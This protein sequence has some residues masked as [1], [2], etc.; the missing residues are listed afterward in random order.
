MKNFFT[1]QLVFKP[2]VSALLALALTLIISADINSDTLIS[3]LIGSSDIEVSDFYN[4]VRAGSSRKHF[5]DEII[6]VNIDSVFDRGELALILLSLLEADVKSVGFDVILQDDK[7]FESD[8]FLKDVLESSPKIVASQK[9][10]V[11]TLKPESDF[12]SRYD[13]KV[14]RGMANLVTKRNSDMVRNFSPSMKGE[15]EYLTLPSE[16]IRSLDSKAFSRLSSLNHEEMI[17]FRPTEFF[18]IEPKDIEDNKKL[19]KDKIVFLGTINEKDDLHHTPLSR[20]TPGVLIQ[21]NILSMMLHEDYT[22]GKS[23]YFNLFFGIISCLGLSFLYVFLDNSQNLAIRIIPIVWIFIVILI[24]CWWFDSFA[25]YINAP[26]TMLLTAFAILVLDFWT[27]LEK[28]FNKL[29]IKL[30]KSKNET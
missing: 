29:M 27:A 22:S 10:N 21:A 4:R 30:K 17:R 5:D 16:M 15:K 25:I 14:R 26:Q 7:E 9:F 11:H 19:L 24:G 20:E 1:N 13:V 6:V 3:T 12:L 18:V 23:R 8:M 28:P 2:V